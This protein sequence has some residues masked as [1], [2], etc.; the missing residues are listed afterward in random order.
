MFCSSR[1]CGVLCAAIQ[2]HVV[3]R[4]V[5]AAP[6]LGGVVIGEEA[7][8]TDALGPVRAPFWL[9][10]ARVKLGWCNVARKDRCGCGTAQPFET[11]R[12]TKAARARQLAHPAKARDLR[13]QRP[14]PQVIR[15][16]IFSVDQP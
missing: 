4:E 8:S 7:K 10:D 5:D 14:S 3:V 15:S 6:V 13:D 2:R 1:F 16:A 12:N 9:L 11:K